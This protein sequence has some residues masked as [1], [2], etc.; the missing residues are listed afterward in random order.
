MAR[1]QQSAAT[2]ARGVVG[3]AQ[4]GAIRALPRQGPAAT[5]VASS[6]GRRSPWPSTPIT[7]TSAPFAPSGRG[8]RAKAWPR[9]PAAPSAPRS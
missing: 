7:T 6:P 1:G 8:P 9:V 3:A 4:R 5:I 2:E